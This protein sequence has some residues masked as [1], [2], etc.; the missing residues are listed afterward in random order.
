VTALIVR[1]VTHHRYAW[2]VGVPWLPDSLDDH[3]RF[4]IAGLAR[5]YLNLAEAVAGSSD[6]GSALQFRILAKESSEA[7]DAGLLSAWVVGAAPDERSAHTLWELASAA[8]PSELPLELGREAE[9]KGVMSWISDPVQD[10]LL[11]VRRR[12]EDARP[13]PGISVD[14]P[15]E[16]TV[17]RWEVA[18]NALRTAMTL[19]RKQPGRSCIVLHMERAVPSEDLLLRL[20]ESFQS[21]LGAASSAPA[22]GEYGPLLQRM[23]TEARHRIRVLPRGALQVRVAIAS[24]EVLRPGI[25]EAVG[26]DLTSLGGFEL[27][28][29]R[30]PVELADAL[31]LLTE[32]EA[33]EWQVSPD[34]VI[35]ELR[36]ISDPGEAAAVVRLPEPPR[37]GLPGINSVP[38]ITLPK[39]PQP[40]AS[41]RTSA[42]VQ[43]GRSPY[44]G[45]VTLTL[46]ELN[47][48]CLVAGLPGFGKTNTSHTILRQLW[49]EHGI[50]FLVL[51]PAKSDYGELLAALDKRDNV[52]PLRIVLTPEIMAFNPFVVPP[53]SSI[54]TH[55]GRVLGAFDAALQI[56]ALWPMGYIMLSRGVF[57]AYEQCKPGES[58]TLRSVYAALGDLIRSTPLDSRS[59]GDVTA[60]LLGR[61]E[62]MVRGPL[63]EALTGGTDAGI[64][65]DDLLS[66]P[67]IVEFRGFAGP[68]ER[69]LIFGLLIA[70]LASVRESEG[71]AGRLRHITVLEEAHRVLANRGS[72]EAEGVRLLAEAIA[73]L[74]GSGEGFLV[75]DQT[76]TALHPVIR[77]VCGSIIAHRLVER[78]ERETIGSALL[79]DNRQTD[80]LARL[81]V[82][83][84]VVYGAS[85]DASVVVDVDRRLHQRPRLHPVVETFTAGGAEPLFCVGCTAMC[86]HERAGQKLAERLASDRRQP[87]ELI[88]PAVLRTESPNDVWCGIAH[89][90]A[91]D[92]PIRNAHRSMFVQLH[93]LR[94]EL[95]RMVRELGPTTKPASAAGPAPSEQASGPVAGVDVA[96]SVISPRPG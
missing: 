41:D 57:R 28:R 53:G 8:L 2:V 3:E 42:S 19:L 13:V 24:T 9:T 91:A 74:R 83:R 80:D 15:S 44:G 75:V 21:A 35:E 18:P 88:A 66:R 73:E 10:G 61:I 93:D 27:V 70:G 89:A 46:G 77:K 55:A 52:S 60:S 76:P 59:K 7:E 51:D 67:V 40:P 32:G 64:D 54:A 85:R 14:E 49:N 86:G 68:T 79:L 4:G 50:P 71:G 90:V 30:D 43:V 39:S 1:A 63:G 82:G 45:A 81:P 69:S 34:P 33:R 47:Q 31:A 38:M 62:H 37:G 5:S 96:G 20:A 12:I 16:A 94:M 11:E 29:P 17:L 25:A 56:S 36:Y 84:A 78:A 58:P 95:V 92:L 23:A 22:G 48:H 65:W 72:V 26:M 6:L 87:E